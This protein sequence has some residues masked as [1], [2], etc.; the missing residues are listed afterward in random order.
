[1]RS[2]RVAT[3]RRCIAGLFAAVVAGLPMAAHAS[4]LPEYGTQ[5]GLAC[6]ASTCAVRAT[7]RLLTPPDYAA[8]VALSEA[9]SA[10]ECDPAVLASS[11]QVDLDWNSGGCAQLVGHGA[12]PQIGTGFIQ[13]NGADNSAAPTCAAVD[14]SYYFGVAFPSANLGASIDDSGTPCLPGGNCAG[15]TT[16]ELTLDVTGYAN[17]T[18]S[19]TSSVTSN[20]EFASAFVP[21]TV[22]EPLAG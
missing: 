22:I 11:I 2:S 19:V 6:K 5:P 14:A 1:M 18:Y 13:L 4:V 16:F 8:C 7:L 21:W 3:A 15:Q 20:G 9:G 17:G 12:Y 10:N